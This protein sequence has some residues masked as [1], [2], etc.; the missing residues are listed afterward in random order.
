MLERER[1][2]NFRFLFQ[3]ISYYVTIFS[4]S[5]SRARSTSLFGVT[6]AFET[7]LVLHEGK[8]A[9]EVQG[10]FDLS[11]RFNLAVAIG[12][13]ASIFQNI[14]EIK[15]HRIFGVSQRP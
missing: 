15:K 12:M 2:R 5:G 6:P 14:I 4:D 1:A 13:K 3:Q 8:T 9:K 11:C 7:V 10:G